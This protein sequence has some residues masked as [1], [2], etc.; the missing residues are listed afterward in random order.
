VKPLSL[1]FLLTAG[2]PAATISGIN[3]TN[4]SP[5]DSATT[6]GGRILEFRSA[7]NLGAVTSAGNMASFTNHFQWMSALLIPTGGATVANIQFAYPAFD[8][9]FTVDDPGNNGYTLRVDSVVRG[10]VAAVFAT[11]PTNGSVQAIGTNLAAYVDTGSGFPVN[12]TLPLRVPGVTSTATP[13]APL[14]SQT[15]ASTADYI[16]GTFTGTRTFALRF[17]N[18][19]SPATSHALQNNVTGEASARFGLAPTLADFV[20]ADYPG[21]DGELA[22]QHGHFLTITAEFNAGT[23][24]PEPGAAGLLALGCGVLLFLRTRAA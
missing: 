4:T 23:G 14:E 22:A 8:I 19:P 24:V 5:A 2:L 15:A 20:L 17:A 7:N 21:T 9:S 16:I 18:N 3:F 10:I 11:G 12:P 6:T 13:T 1:L